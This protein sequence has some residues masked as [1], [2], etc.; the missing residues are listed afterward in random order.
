MV[1]FF[2]RLNPGLRATLTRNDREGTNLQQLLRNAQEVWGTFTNKQQLHKC[3]LSPG[4]SKPNRALKQQTGSRQN[5]QS[6]SGSQ[7]PNTISNEECQRRFD[8]QLCFK[9]GKPDHLARDCKSQENPT[10][11]PQSPSE[12]TK[13]QSIKQGSGHKKTRFQAATVPDDQSDAQDEEFADTGELSKN[14]Q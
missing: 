10:P 6:N 12:P 5:N 9:C 3:T 1:D 11:K 14:Q 8:N 4:S 7:Q 13:T 2:P